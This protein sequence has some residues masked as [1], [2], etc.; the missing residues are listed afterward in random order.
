MA[1]NL[2]KVKYHGASHHNKVLT[3]EGIKKLAE[4]NTIL[5]SPELA[6]Q[7]TE[8]GK[9]WSTTEDLKKYMKKAPVKFVED[10]DDEVETEEDDET[11][12]DE[13]DDE[14]EEEESDDLGDD[15]IKAII[16]SIPKMSTKKLNEAAEEAGLNPDDFE[17]RSAL[18][19]KLI[20]VLKGKE[21][22]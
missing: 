1:Q 17:S 8:G 13:E 22:A 3:S 20:K 11:E 21:T 16:K 5:V 9:S 18:V 19:K 6:I 10:E 15:E 2:V 4:D 14:D 12:E 7:L